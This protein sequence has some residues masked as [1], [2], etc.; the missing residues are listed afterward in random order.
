MDKETKLAYL[1]DEIGMID[2]RYVNEVL[3]AKENRRAATK[4]RTIALLA[5]VVA[6]LVLMIGSL[7]IGKI[8]WDRILEN[9]QPPHSV[10]A[11]SLEERIL[12]LDTERFEKLTTAEDTQAALHDGSVKL[13]FRS[14]AE[15]Y[16]FITVSDQK[17]AAKL[18]QYLSGD[19]NKT[20]VTDPP[21]AHLQLW[22]S[23]GNGHVLTPYLL[24]ESGGGAYGVLPDYAIEAYPS[25]SF[26]DFI[27]SLLQET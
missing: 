7:W 19:G 10:D 12:A 3:L 16:R 20:P 14:D 25:A 6:A 4:R 9:A 15:E 5:A 27:L 24:E 2:D 22:V 23:L 11:T 1:I 18:R 21:K 17:D 13:I 26:E 8:A